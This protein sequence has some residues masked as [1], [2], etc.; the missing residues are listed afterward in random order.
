M[1]SSFFKRAINASLLLSLFTVI[2]Y[3]VSLVTQSLLAKKLT[4]ADF[5]E[6]AIVVMVIMFFIT[7]TSL[8]S[9][10]Y[11]YTTEKNILSEVVIIELVLAVI[12][13][14]IG[15]LSIES[16]FDFLNFEGFRPE[17]IGLLALCFYM[18]LARVRAIHEK[19][20][21]FV[22][23][24]TPYFLGQLLAPIIALLSLNYGMGLYSILIWKLS[25]L[26]IEVL[27]LNVVYFNLYNEPNFKN[28]EFK[29]YFKFSLPL[30]GAMILVFVYS[31]VDYAI[32][33]QLLSPAELGGYW[34][35]FQFTN[36]LLQGRK[37]IISIA[38]PY[39]SKIQD[40]RKIMGIT[41]TC[42]ALMIGIFSIPLFLFLLH[43]EWLITSIFGIEW[44]KYNHLFIIF[45]LVIMLRSTVTFL[46]PLCVRYKYTDLILKATIISTV[47]VVMVGYTMTSKFGVYGMCLAVFSSVVISNIYSIQSLR[48]RGL[49]YSCGLIFIVLFI[50]SIDIF[51]VSY[52][53]DLFLVDSNLYSVLFTS[54]F[55]M[56]LL[57]LQF[58]IYLK[59]SKKI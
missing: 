17:F 10:K 39:I 9:D 29:S 57:S 16:V 48:K 56:V 31:N 43:G 40:V 46:E 24:R 27:I 33:S 54:V 58:L 15:F 42:T 53:F 8:S 7:I 32:I 59:S 11:I 45:S 23:A 37:I 20:I 12:V 49:D 6:S 55:Y 1:M 28:F 3:L 22:K 19:N 2:Q 30:Q 4:D 38:T 21:D 26:L 18:P 13:I 51:I 5:G 35:A 50:I 34:L 36:Q 41:H 47:I 52:A 14:S 25:S 44:V